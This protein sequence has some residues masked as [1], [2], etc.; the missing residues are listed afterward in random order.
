MDWPLPCRLA[1]SGKVRPSEEH[2]ADGALWIAKRREIVSLQPSL[3]TASAG[4]FTNDCA[5]FHSPLHWHGMGEVHD[6]RGG[7]VSDELMGLTVLFYAL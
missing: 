6:W 3:Q 5:P 4:A 7:A 2:T 1:G